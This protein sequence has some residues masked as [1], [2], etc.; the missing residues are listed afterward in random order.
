ALRKAIELD[1][2]RPEGTRF[3]VPSVRLLDAAAELFRL[4]IPPQDILAVIAALRRNL[5]HTSAALIA[6]VDQ[7]I[8]ATQAGTHAAAAADAPQL[9]HVLRQLQPLME[10]AVIPEIARAMQGAASAQFGEHLATVP[11]C[12]SSPPAT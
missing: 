2:I 6:L 4:G 8:G 1:L 10:M 11:A 7:Q 3:C 9:A 12:R 5:E